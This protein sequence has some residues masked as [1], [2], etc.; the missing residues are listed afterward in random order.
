VSD[1]PD[2]T[3][4]CQPDTPVSAPPDRQKP[5]LQQKG[6]QGDSNTRS[7]SPQKNEG[8]TGYASPSVPLQTTGIPSSLN[9]G[10]S[11][12][13]VEATKPDHTTAQHA[14]SLGRAGAASVLD[15]VREDLYH[16]ALVA[17]RE[18]NDQ[19]PFRAT[20]SRLVNLYQ[21]AGLPL[22]EFTER[23]D[24]ARQRTKERTM[25]IRTLAGEG[26]GHGFAKKNKVPYFFA[27]FED[28]LGFR[29]SPGLPHAD[30][31]AGGSPPRASVTGAARR[32]LECP[33]PGH[34]PRGPAEP[35]GGASVA[36]GRPVLGASLPRDAE[37]AQVINEIVREFS[38]QFT[39]YG[40]AEALGEWAVT[41]WRASGLA[42]ER[43]L[44]VANGAAATML[45][46]RTAR[47]SAPN[48]QVRLAD[49]LNQLVGAADA[50]VQNR[51]V[52]APTGR[53]ATTPQHHAGV[54][55]R[56]GSTK[57]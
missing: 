45:A 25:A 27:I 33:L 28:L 3:V 35:T 52:P 23:F 40:A 38:R 51:A 29:A 16:F 5:A 48:Y 30:E 14:D 21:G 37:D 20:L 56:V 31:D 55:T 24:A 19:A 46:D 8:R 18:F 22:E 36:P 9:R 1:L 13:D 50:E 2:T 41:R 44:E 53:R 34:P 26:A 42:R 49:A 7:A 12:E 15:P 4:S 6:D 54:A 17:A 57:L 43:F 39:D 10:H 11:A 47:P 32:T